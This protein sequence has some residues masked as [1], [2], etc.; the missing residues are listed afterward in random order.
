MID[1]VLINELKIFDNIALKAEEKDDFFE[2]VDCLVANAFAFESITEQNS[3]F[4][5]LKKYYPIVYE[6]HCERSELL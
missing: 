6:Q 1:A 4:E 2:A 5:E 3:N